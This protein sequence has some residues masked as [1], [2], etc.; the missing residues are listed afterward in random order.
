MK[1]KL[2]ALSLA[3]TFLL[4]AAE[5]LP[6]KPPPERTVWLLRQ[7]RRTAR[8]LDDTIDKAGIDAFIALP[9]YK[10]ITLTKRLLQ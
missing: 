8:L 3:L 1:K 4:L 2:L 10:G 6:E 7:S 5:P 9:E